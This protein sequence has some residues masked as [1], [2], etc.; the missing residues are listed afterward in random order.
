MVLGAEHIVTGLEHLLCL[1]V[2]LA[3]MMVGMAV[4]DFP[5]R[6]KGQLVSPWLRLSL[7]IACALIHGLGFA[8]ALAA[9]A[10]DG[11]HQWPNL[12][13][14]DAGIQLGQVAVSLRGSSLVR[15]VRT[16]HYTNW[17]TSSKSRRGG[18]GLSWLRSP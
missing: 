16:S 10:L 5:A 6:R 2:V 3:A 1:L 12:A 8:S 13:G 9:F 4:F 18:R 17:Q 15:V 14:F 11:Q 7:V